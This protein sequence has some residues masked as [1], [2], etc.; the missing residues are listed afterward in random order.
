VVDVPIS[1]LCFRLYY[2][3]VYNHRLATKKL[4]KIYLI[5]LLFVFLVHAFALAGSNTH[6]V[7][8]LRFFAIIGFISALP[9]STTHRVVAVYKIC[10]A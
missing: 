6:W 2:S 1:E 3:I 4:F 5:S 8:A 9:R 10:L 7:F